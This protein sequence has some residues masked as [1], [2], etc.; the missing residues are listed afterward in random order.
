MA[1]GKKDQCGTCH[2]NVT[3][4]QNGVLCKSCY[5]WYHASC[6][7]LTEEDLEAI[8][9]FKGLSY[10]CSSCDKNPR[11]SDERQLR[12]EI[13]TLT[14][15]FDAFVSKSDEEYRSIKKA[16]AD[17]ISDF[18]RD[19]FSTL[20]EMKTDISA[21]SKLVKTVEAST[22]AKI[23]QLENDNN[24]LHRK[25]N[26]S[27]LIISGLPV[28]LPNLIEP[29]MEL[30]SFYKVPISQH[31]LNHVCYINNKKSVLVRFNRVLV[32]D[33]I[34]KMYFKTIKTQSLVVTDLIKL[35]TGVSNVQTSSSSD[36]TGAQN[37]TLQIK[38]RVF[39]NDH[40]SPAAGK[41]NA[42]CKKLHK[43]KVV[44]KFRVMD[45]D[46]PKARLTLSD[47][48]EIVVG[49]TECAALLEDDH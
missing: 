40:Y 27:N 12:G 46:K 4:T 36:A 42:M 14:N 5:L 32:R 25:F 21:C 45:A 10:V 8:K 31:D 43:D 19:V 39:L 1:G 20:N 30:G 2:A 23:L 9:E 28:G 34:M 11:N 47:G 18:K 41:L 33:E 13:A 29:V 22:S 49:V 44:L 16:F 24:A 3:K 37:D 15:K 17:V 35:D 38:K 7:N 48:K 6:V 26:R